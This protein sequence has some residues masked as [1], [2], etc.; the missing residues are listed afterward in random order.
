MTIVF[1]GCDNVTCKL[2]RSRPG[3]PEQPTHTDYSRDRKVSRLNAF[4]Y[5][6]IIAIQQNTYILVG[7]TRTR[8]D[9]PI[10]SMICFRGDMPHAGGG[11]QEDHCRI[12]LFL[13]RQHRV[14]LQT[15][16]ILYCD[17]ITIRECNLLN[18]QHSY[19]SL[20]KQ[21]QRSQ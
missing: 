18:K 9:L 5:S 21:Q 12:S 13:Y 6:A 15:K 1:P 20:L 14:Q 8:I 19:N 11:Y 4:N 17:V 3:D 7:K 10:R 16:S 2:L